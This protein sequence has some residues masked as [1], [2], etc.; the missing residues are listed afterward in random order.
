MS[1]RPLVLLAAVALALP[2]GSAAQDWR[3]ITSMRQVGRE[4]GLTV[5]LEYGAGQLDLVAGREGVLYRSSLRYDAEVIQPHMS[6]RSGT[7]RL[8]LEDIRVRGRNMKSGQLRL[9]LGPGV[10]LDLD[11]QFGAARANIDLTGLSVRSLKVATGASETDLRIEQPNPEICEEMDLDVGA[12]SFRA[13]GIGNLSP[14]RVEFSGGVGEVTLDFTGSARADMDVGIEMGLGKL[15]LRVPRGSGVRVHKS[16]LLVGFDSQELIKRGDMYYSQDW[17]SA[18][19]RITFEVQAALGS[20][21]V[22][23]VD[24]DNLEF[25][26]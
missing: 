25:R 20:V 21:R 8:G 16:G 12:A 7:L 10:P 6:Y 24:P 3:T 15:T 22:V 14:R 11:L 19:R 1:E 9:E 23:W 5:D 26:Q 17:E 4:N 13:Y 18:R 2:T